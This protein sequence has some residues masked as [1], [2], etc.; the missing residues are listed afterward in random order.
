MCCAADVLEGKGAVQ[1]AIT[2]CELLRN[3]TPSQQLKSPQRT[4]L[5]KT[6]SSITTTTT[7]SSTI[8][9]R[10]I[11]LIG[12]IETIKSTPPPSSSSSP[13]PQLIPNGSLSSSPSM[14]P[15]PTT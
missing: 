8:K 12:G 11:P 9:T 15:P 6:L 13:P 7:T 3:Y 4:I 10:E 5:T 1:I 14:P 2:V